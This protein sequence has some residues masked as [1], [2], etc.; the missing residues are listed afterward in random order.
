MPITR[1]PYSPVLCPIVPNL[2][3]LTHD[4][5]WH[6]FRSFDIRGTAF[7]AYTADVKCTVSY[8]FSPQSV[9][10]SYAQLII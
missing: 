5:D 2:D 1:P 10:R 9:P 4:D 3:A 8:S 7:T 6:V